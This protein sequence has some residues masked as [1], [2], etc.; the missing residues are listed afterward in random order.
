[1]ASPT[2]GARGAGGGPPSP[3]EVLRAL[4]GR[5]P[6]ERRTRADPFQVL[7]ATVISQ[8]TKE[9]STALASRRLLGRFPDAASLAAAPAAEVER[10]IRPSGFYR[11]KARTLV[12]LA[13]A[14]MQEHRGRVPRSLE[15]LLSLP[16][17]GRKTANC[18]LVYAFGVPAIPVDTHVH[19][20]SGRLG[21]ARAASPEETERALSALIPRERWLDINEL[22]VLFGR[23]LCRPIGPRCGECPIARCPS[24]RAPAERGG[25]GRARA[26]GV[27]STVLGG[28]G[29]IVASRTQRK[30]GY[31]GRGP[32]GA[33]RGW[34]GGAR[35]C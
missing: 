27:R 22:L 5:Y 32:S 2:H 13:R 6:R 25:R 26:G 8:R 16:G 15:G 23:E 34:R 4:R 21:W 3:A 18:V 33:G 9:E 30:K 10:L 11:N 29:R 14:L 28:L 35:T 7:V 1:M 20:V 24:R 12:W 19:R 31:E 17:V